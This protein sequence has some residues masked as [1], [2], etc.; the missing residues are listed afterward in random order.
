MAAVTQERLHLRVT[1][2]SSSNTSVELYLQSKARPVYTA[3][4]LLPSAHVELHTLWM[5]L[6]SWL[7]RDH[8]GNITLLCRGI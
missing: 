2:F 4:L 7:Q 5:G 8:V 3:C 1:I 6:S